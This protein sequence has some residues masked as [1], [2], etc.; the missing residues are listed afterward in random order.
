MID[1]RGLINMFILFE[2]WDKIFATGVGAAMTGLGLY[3]NSKVKKK[4]DKKKVFNRIISDNRSLFEVVLK[5]ATGEGNIDY[6][7]LREELD[8]SSILLDLWDEPRQEFIEL[9]RIHSLDPDEYNKSKKEIYPLLC[10]IESEFEKCG[11]D[12][13]GK[14]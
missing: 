4:D 14:R 7:A 2:V 12:L 1:R 5:G 6:I 13:F 9:Y 11:V 3:V 8:K 10:K